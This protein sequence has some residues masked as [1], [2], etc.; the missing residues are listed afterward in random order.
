MQRSSILDR[1]LK[2]FDVMNDLRCPLDLA[3]GL[4]SSELSTSMVA[5]F[6][7]CAL[8]IVKKLARD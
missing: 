7:I 5:D 4:S 2:W 1:H 6:R 8:E 3:R